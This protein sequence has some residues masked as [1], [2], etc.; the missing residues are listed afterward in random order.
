MTVTRSMVADYVEA[1]FDS[2][3]VERAG[4]LKAA[5]D[6]H[7]PVEVF[8]V[9]HSLPGRNYASLRDLWP[10]LSHLPVE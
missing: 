9:L 8:D 2:P 6:A 10:D 5:I 4:L 3:P 1:A 7:A